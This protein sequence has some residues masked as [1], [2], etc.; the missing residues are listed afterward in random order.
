MKT[1]P[2]VLLAATFNAV[3]AGSCQAVAASTA[4][5][6]VELY[7]SEGCSS[8]PPADR[9]LS[10][11]KGRRDVLALAFHVNY[12]DQLG[13][14]DR[15]A[16]PEITARQHQIVRW[17]GGPY[18]YTPQVVVNGRDSR[19]DV[20]LPKATS[21]SPVTVTLSREGERVTA[22]VGGANAGAARFDAYWA[23]TEDGYQSKVHTGENAGETLRHDHVVRLYRPI[24]AWP[25]A[26]GTRDELVVSPGVAEHPRRVIFVVTDASTHRPVQAV[27]LAC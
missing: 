3:A 20:S 26:E 16:T 14:V 9:W 4:P 22:Q 19:A 7:T 23:V 1:W 15:F 18:V 10:T 5:T 8:C 25:A 12:W 13:W 21:A 24:A 11:L 27:A 2:F 6:V 17:Q